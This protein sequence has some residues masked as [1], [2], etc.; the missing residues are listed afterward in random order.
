MYEVFPR[1]FFGGVQ[2][3]PTTPTRCYHACSELQGLLQ[4]VQE[5]LR[6]PQAAEGAAEGV[7][8]KAPTK[9]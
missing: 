5:A 3:L 6:Q 9:V 4:A 1:V 8:L 2:V 7:L